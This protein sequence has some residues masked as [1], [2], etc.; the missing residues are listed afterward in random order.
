[1]PRQDDEAQ[2]IEQLSQGDSLSPFVQNNGGNDWY[3]VK[4]QKGLM[5][6]V[7][8]TDVREDTGSK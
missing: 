6:W 8:S 1:L 5:G 3:M 4:T 7:K 2:K